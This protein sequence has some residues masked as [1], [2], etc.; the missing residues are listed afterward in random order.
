[1]NLNAPTDNVVTA[2][3]DK[4]LCKAFKLALLNYFDEN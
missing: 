1:M 2:L 3:K 4:S